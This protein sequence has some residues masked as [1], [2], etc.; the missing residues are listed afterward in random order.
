MHAPLPKWAKILM[1]LKVFNLSLANDSQACRESARQVLGDSTMPGSF[2][3]WMARPVRAHARL[4]SG[5][6]ISDDLSLRSNA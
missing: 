3:V 6:K 1:T 4:Q 2:P 5:Q